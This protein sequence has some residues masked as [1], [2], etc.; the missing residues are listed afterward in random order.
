MRNSLVGRADHGD[1]ARTAACRVSR[2]TADLVRSRWQG[3]HDIA[4]ED[5]GVPGP[6][7]AAGFARSQALG[8]KI[9][10]ASPKIDPAFVGSD[11]CDGSELT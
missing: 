4:G 11:L 7:F 8:R 10:G 9:F 6:R 2:N 5:H 1:G 3:V